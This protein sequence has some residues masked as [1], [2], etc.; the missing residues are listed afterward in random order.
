MGFIKAILITSISIFL[1]AALVPAISYTNWG[2]LIVASIVLT[3]LQKVVEPVLKILFLPI[4]IITL[5]VFSWVINLL[6]MYLAVLLVPGFH[7]NN[8]IIGSYHLGSIFTLLLVSF[9]LSLVESVID[10]VI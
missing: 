2:T 9:A 3:I 5:G 1:L 4:N 8:L 7:I 10:L 6:I